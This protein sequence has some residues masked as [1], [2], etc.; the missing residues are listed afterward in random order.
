MPKPGKTRL[1]L[2]AFFGDGCLQ[3]SRGA[4]WNAVLSLAN[5]LSLKK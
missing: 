3:L 4:S 1:W 5:A 2:I